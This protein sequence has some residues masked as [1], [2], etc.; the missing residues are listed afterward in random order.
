MKRRKKFKNMGE[1]LAFIKAMNRRG[2][3]AL[4][5]LNKQLK[6]EEKAYQDLLADC[7]A[8]YGDEF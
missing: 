2:E 1:M 8:K 3:E 6:E 4:K 7:K 5:K